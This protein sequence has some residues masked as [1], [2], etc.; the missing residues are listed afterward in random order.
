MERKKIA[1][2]EVYLSNWYGFIDEF[3]PIDAVNTF[4]TG[5]NE[6]GKST[7]IDAIKY[8]FMDDTQFNKGAETKGHKKGDAQ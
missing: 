4:I 2:V 1:L 8:A 6:S 3:I 7:I 5:E